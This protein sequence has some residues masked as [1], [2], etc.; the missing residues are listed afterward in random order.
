MG[1]I[2]G[3]SKNKGEKDMLAIRNNSF[4]PLKSWFGGLPISDVLKDV[5]DTS[6]FPSLSL[7]VDVKET[8]DKVVLTADIPGVPKE[9]IDIAVNE[10]LLTIS[11]ERKEEK[12]EENERYSRRERRL[13]KVS[14][15]FRLD[16]LN[17]ESISASMD[18]GV[19]KIEISKTPVTVPKR[20]AVK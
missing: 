17:P 11:Y 13:G 15:S 16:D 3:E 14:R 7:E 6:E 8:P 2:H 4:V 5:F 1:Q 18:N 10:G 20:I 9:N 19:L 12:A